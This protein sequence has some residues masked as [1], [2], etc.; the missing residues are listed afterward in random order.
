MGP[1]CS[2]RA[3]ARSDVPGRPIGPELQKP[4]VSQGQEH[5]CDAWLVPLWQRPSPV[6]VCVCVVC[7]CVRVR[8]CVPW[9]MRVCL[10]VRTTAQYLPHVRRIRQHRSRMPGE[11]RANRRSWQ[12]VSSLQPVTITLHLRIPNLTGRLDPANPAIH[13][14]IRIAVSGLAYALPLTSLS[15]PLAHALSH[16]NL[17]PLLLTL[18]GQWRCPLATRRRSMA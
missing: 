10:R 16:L 12:S 2:P 13:V 4:M 11:K 6:C 3:S 5:T 18:Q 9:C 1:V 7:V 8:A 14:A 15:P 17:L